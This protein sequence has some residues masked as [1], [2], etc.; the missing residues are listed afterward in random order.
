MGI[1]RFLPE[2]IKGPVR[3]LKNRLRRLCLVPLEE[4]P[5]SPDMF[6]DYRRL[7]ACP[8][9]ER[10]SGGWLYKGRFY[11]DHLTVG[12][13]A[14]GIL[15]QAQKLCRGDGVD[16]GA[17]FWPLPG[18]APVDLVRGEGYGKT[19]DDFAD[20]SLNYVFSSHCLEHI[21][22]WQ[23]ALLQWVAKLRAG[24]IIL[25]YLPHPDCAIWHP[26]SPFVNDQ[27][28]WSPTPEIIK[29]SLARLQCEIASFDDG[30]DGM[31]S[32]Y[33]VGCK[34]GIQ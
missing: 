8:E 20:N 13:A 11:G 7:I 33:V 6:R 12:A 15:R 2:S 22:N 31:E 18:A 5:D 21:D 4:L 19:L 27:H 30:P 14:H 16:I 9:V 3:R 17:G 25:L 32:F 29:Q 23:E 28:K 1:K 10:K 24:G 34:R 26:G